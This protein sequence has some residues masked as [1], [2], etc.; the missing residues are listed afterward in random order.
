M[1][2]YKNALLLLNDLDKFTDTHG[3]PEAEQ[4][5]LKAKQALESDLGN[6][7]PLVRKSPKPS[8]VYRIQQT[9]NEKTRFLPS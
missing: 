8:R 4:L 2:S 5:I 7:F 9:A 6:T 1:T 3:F